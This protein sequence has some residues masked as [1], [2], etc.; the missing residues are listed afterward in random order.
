MYSEVLWF[1]SFLKISLG[2]F[3]AARCPKEP[4]EAHN[5]LLRVP[6][7]H[8]RGTQ[9]RP[10]GAQEDPRGAQEHPRGTQEA[11]KRHLRGTQESPRGTQEAPKTLHNRDPNLKKWRSKN[12]M[13]ADSILSW[14][15]GGFGE[16][17]GRFFGCKNDAQSENAKHRKS[18]QN[19]GCAHRISI[20]AHQKTTK[21]RCRI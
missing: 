18:L 5:S 10:Q 8:P 13:F 9:E 17:F 3:G 11:T 14:F 7:G 21:N 1:S 12:N 16:V 2:T 4:Q 6:R 19:I 20:S 15:R